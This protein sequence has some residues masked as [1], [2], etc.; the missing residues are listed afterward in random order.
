MVGFVSSASLFLPVQEIAGANPA[1]DGLITLPLA[2]LDVP[3][4]FA[5]VR[6]HKVPVGCPACGSNSLLKWGTRRRG[7][8]EV[9]RFR[10]RG[11]GGTFCE[12][13]GTPLEA[14]KVSAAQAVAVWHRR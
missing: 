2:A 6:W 4:A 3:G 13:T 7:G 1:P 12:F 8:V 9:M 5:A 11:C 10:C 14:V